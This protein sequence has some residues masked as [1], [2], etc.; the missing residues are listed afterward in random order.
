VHPGSLADALAHECT[1]LD[2]AH[3]RDGGEALTVYLNATEFSSL[4]V[5]EYDKAGALTDGPF[6]ITTICP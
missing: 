6:T 1:V 2:R 5:A 4:V 3:H